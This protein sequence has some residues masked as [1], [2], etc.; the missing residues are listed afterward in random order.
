MCQYTDTALKHTGALALQCQHI[1]TLVQKLFLHWRFAFEK[2]CFISNLTE[3]FWSRWSN[4]GRRTLFA[5][6]A[7]NGK[8]SYRF[9]EH[10]INDQKGAVRLWFSSE[11]MHAPGVS[12][13]ST[14]RP[15]VV[16]Y[17]RSSRIANVNATYTID[18]TFAC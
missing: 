3:V 6:G 13:R 16:S 5:E 11:A 9:P 12:H 7:L 2:A 18:D 10:K 1:G 17:R 8:R 4:G 14:P 15:L